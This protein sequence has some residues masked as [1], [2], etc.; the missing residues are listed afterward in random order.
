MTLN[1][2]QSRQFTVTGP[3]FGAASNYLSEMEI[4]GSI[5]ENLENAVASARRL[6]GRRVYSDTLDY[7]VSLIEA[8][9]REQQ[10]ISF[11]KSTSL[12]DVI[13]MLEFEITKH[14]LHNA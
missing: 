7:W 11:A 5:V 6:R 13:T 1:G 10:H 9:R 8:A 3:Y 14:K 12:D 4:H 2:F